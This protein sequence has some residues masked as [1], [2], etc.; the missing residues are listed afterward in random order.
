MR[1]KGIGINAYPDYINGDFRKLKESWQRFHEVGYDYVEIPID[2]VDVAHGGRFDP[3]MMEAL[4]GLLKGF[5][6][7]IH[8]ARPLGPRFAGYTDEKGYNRSFSERVSSLPLKLGSMSSFI[9]TDAG[10][11]T[12]KWKKCSTGLC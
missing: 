12:K 11:I 9:T 8:R 6:L 2:A 7:K 4:K 1:V 10:P 5:A 3:A